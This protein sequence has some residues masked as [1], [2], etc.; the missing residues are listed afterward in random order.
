MALA[1]LPIT[2]YVLG[3]EDYGAFAVV[4]GVTAFA[5][6]VATGSATFLVS[7]HFQQA[8]GDERRELVTTLLATAVLLGAAFAAILS[9]LWSVIPLPTGISGQ[10]D[11]ASYRLALFAMVLSIPWSVASPVLVVSGRPLL[12]AATTLATTFA[13]AGATV[14]ALYVYEAG[15]TSLFVGLVAGAL[16]QCGGAIAS[17]APYLGSRISPSVLSRAARLTVFGALGNALEVMQV[18]VERT[19]L[20]LHAGLHSLGLYAHAQQ[21]RNGA[22]MPVKAFAN[23]IWPTTLTEAGTPAEG[24]PQTQ[25]GWTILYATI[26]CFGI[27]FACVGREAVSLLTHGKFEGAAPYATTLLA[28][29]LVQFSGR[30]QLGVLYAR[31]RG[32]YLSTWMG[33]SAATGIALLL[34]LVPAMGAPGAIVALY[35]QQL[36]YRLGIHWRSK[37]EGSFPFGDFGAIRNL[38]M[39]FAILIVSEYFWDSI[40]ARLV[41]LIGAVILQCTLE[42]KTIADLWQLARSRRTPA[43]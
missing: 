36:A 5:A 23:A 17:L 3:P 24:F 11:G 34:V 19:L 25:R 33:V 1:V 8:S 41:L 38:A 29:L 2:T 7:A 4:T 43:P 16:A 22:F 18:M 37:K 20:A 26:G 31:D 15:R 35:A 30:P 39:V 10:I 12:F 9:A 32:E 13:V 42:R 14:V 40:Q 21:Y 27:L 28:L 6:S